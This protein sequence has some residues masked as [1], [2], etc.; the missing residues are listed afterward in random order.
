MK[1]EEE[2]GSPRFMKLRELGQETN[3]R[4]LACLNVNYHGVRRRVTKALMPLL[5]LAQSPNIV[6]VSSRRGQ[7]KVRIKLAVSVLFETSCFDLLA[8]V[9]YLA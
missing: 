1:Q 9:T 6:N 8:V 2:D 3:E 5:Q 7:L 4:A